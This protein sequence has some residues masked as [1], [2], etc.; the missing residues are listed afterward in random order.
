[1]ESIDFLKEKLEL[2]HDICPYLEIKYEYRSYINTHIIEVK[3][4]HCFE[5][6]IEYVN[7][8]I[9]LEDDFEESFPDEEIL[10][11]T[12]NELISVENPILELGILQDDCEYDLITPPVIAEYSMNNSILYGVDSTM[13]YEFEIPI[14]KHNH[15]WNRPFK[16]K[17]DSEQYSESFFL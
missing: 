15:W 13:P 14:A 6:D 3:P 12:D 17:K 2:L 8:Q 5:K 10:F 16:N 1:M 4:I 9:L 7:G 11:I